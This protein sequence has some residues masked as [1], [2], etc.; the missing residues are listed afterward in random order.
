MKKR[1][2]PAALWLADT[3]LA[4]GAAATALWAAVLM[5]HW[6][7]LTAIGPICGDPLNVLAHCPLCHSAAAVT[8]AAGAA[9]LSSA[10][11]PGNRT[12]AGLRII[13]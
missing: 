2:T 3:G 13:T 7:M 1:N 10:I 8:V 9:L 12:F 5:R 6:P 11:K 4:L